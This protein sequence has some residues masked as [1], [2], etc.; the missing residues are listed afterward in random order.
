MPDDT[1]IKSLFDHAKGPKLGGGEFPSYP[2]VYATW[3]EQFAN[4]HPPKG[5][6]TSDL[7]TYANGQ[8]K[9]S[10]DKKT[11]TGEVKLWRN[12]YDPAQP[13]FFDSPSKPA[14]AFADETG[15]LTVLLTITDAGKVTYQRKLNGKPVMGLPPVTLNGT[16]DSGLVVEKSGSS[17]RSLSFTLGWTV[18]P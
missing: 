14:N 15:P 4:S 12:V 3:I 9:L 17:L 8:L 5:K 13:S 7:V 11:L 18:M 16:Y 10:A 1:S 6:E 2:V